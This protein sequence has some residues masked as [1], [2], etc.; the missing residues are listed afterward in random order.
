MFAYVHLMPS[1]VVRSLPNFTMHWKICFGTCECQNLVISHQLWFHHELYVFP[2]F[3]PQITKVVAIYQFLNHFPN[4]F[5]PPFFAIHPSPAT[6]RGAPQ[7]RLLSGDAL[8]LRG[9]VVEIEDRLQL[10][11]D[12]DHHGGTTFWI[13]HA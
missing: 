12:V 9:V 11:V 1:F 7:V 6:A 10:G 5:T 2:T 4:H 8:R 3:S 13:G